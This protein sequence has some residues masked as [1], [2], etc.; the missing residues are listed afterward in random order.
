MAKKPRHKQKHTGDF[1]EG[2]F[3]CPEAKCESL[4][5]YISSWKRHLEYAHNYG[6]EMSKTKA[7]MARQELLTDLGTKYPEGRH[8]P[9]A[10]CKA[11]FS[12]EKTIKLHL[13]QKHG[14]SES[15]LDECLK[16]KTDTD[17]QK[18]P[19]NCPKCPKTTVK[20]WTR[21]SYLKKH[22]IR[23]HQ[24]SPEDADKILQGDER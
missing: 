10:E 22:I 8:C 2:G 6:P 13:I 14:V 23:V 16:N 4:M 20:E 11:G 5:L 15:E 18:K 7:D 12:Y 21:L 24:V 17:R 3:K 9:I 1:V 19:L